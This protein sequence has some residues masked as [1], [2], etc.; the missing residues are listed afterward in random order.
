[1]NIQLTPS[2]TARLRYRLSG[3]APRVAIAFTLVVGVIG[4]GVW[5]WPTLTSLQEA[6]FA[7]TPEIVETVDTTTSEEW[8]ALVE[9]RASTRALY[10]TFDLTDVDPEAIDEY[11]SAA[12][13]ADV[14]I[15]NDSRTLGAL[16][17]STRD[18]E[19]AFAGLEAALAFRDNPVEEGAATSVASSAVFCTGPADITFVA[20]GDGN[21][22]LTVTGSGMTESKEDAAQVSITVPVDSGRYVA[23]ATARSGVAIF[24][25]WS[26]SCSTG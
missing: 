20:G 18:L 15:N 16:A 10:E 1:M 7:S 24:A 21:V 4:V 14:L 5:Q 26:G 2:R 22:L 11:L 9:A 19:S 6:V 8:R 17:T 25:E 13:R 12:L 3:R 23:V